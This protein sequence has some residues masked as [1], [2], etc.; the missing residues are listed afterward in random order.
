MPPAARTTGPGV[1]WRV[2]PRYDRH[3]TDPAALL[4]A[5]KTAAS[6]ALGPRKGATR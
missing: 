5:L 3:F 6:A 2:P 4:A 1:H